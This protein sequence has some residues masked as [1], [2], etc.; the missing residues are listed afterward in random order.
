MANIN[1]EMTKNFLKKQL[2]HVP[3]LY[4]TNLDNILLPLA[5]QPFENLGINIAIRIARKYGASVTVL[6]N[7]TRNME[8]YVEKLA[9]FKINLVKKRTTRENISNAI[10]NEANED[11]QLVIMP[12]RRRLKWIDKFFITSISSEVIP[13]IDYD[14]L[15]V[16]PSKGGLPGEEAKVPEFN[17]IA[18]LLSRD[19]RDPKLMFWTNALINSKNTIVSAYHISNIGSI[20]PFASAYDTDVIIQEREKFEEMI[21]GYSEIFGIDIDPNFILSHKIASTSSKLLNRNRPDIV[22]MGQTKKRKWWQIRT[23][24]DKVLDWTETPIIVHHQPV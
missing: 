6:H 12:S 5:C 15:Q 18:L 8:D 21:T 3:D 13:K 9:K 2:D 19:N 4:F 16:F 20:T 23:L 11:Y 17:D 24:T 1:I 22:I 7:G 10:L 14:V